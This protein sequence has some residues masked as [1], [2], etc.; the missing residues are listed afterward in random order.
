VVCAASYFP[1]TMST[2]G[3][4]TA[5]STV[6]RAPS[7]RSHF[8]TSHRSRGNHLRHPHAEALLREHGT[9]ID[10][11]QRAGLRMLAVHP[12]GA[13]DSWE[14]EDLPATYL[15]EARGLAVP[16]SARPGL[17]SWHHLDEATTLMLETARTHEGDRLLD[18]GCGNGVVGTLLLAEGAVASA[19]FCDHDA[20]ALEA[21]AETLS[22][23]GLEGSL[24]ADDAGE[25]LPAKAF[26]L[27]LCN[28]PYHHGTTQE[29]GTGRRMIEQSARALDAK[30][31]LYL[32]APVFH[33]HAGDLERL[34][35]L[36]DLAAET[37]SFRV[38]HAAR[39]RRRR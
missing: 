17:F 13:G 39:P 25:S 20:L 32:V 37:P 26:D 3:R 16:V 29:R 31:R 7:C 24:L 19:T 5:A 27:V 14:L 1:R 15:A 2:Q 9:E 30:G 6:F 11:R 12:L 4:G 34:F 33:N 23:N 22:L 28:P 38:W 35:R 21:A 36:V 18:L 8:S 10:S